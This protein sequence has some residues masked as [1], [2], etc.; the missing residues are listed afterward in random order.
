MRSRKH[1]NQMKHLLILGC[2]LASCSS[3]FSQN[4]VI[5]EKGFASFYSNKFEGRRCSSG[6]VFRQ[7]GLTAAHRHLR[8]G[9]R[10]KVI[11]LKNDSSVIVTINDRMPL[12]GRCDIDL[13]LRAAKQLNFVRQGIARVR[14]EV[15]PDSLN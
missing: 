5:C 14:I 1:R 13:T 15:L 4:R 12:R 11:N 6:E 3:G 8:F 10:V 7:Q 2:I 9:T